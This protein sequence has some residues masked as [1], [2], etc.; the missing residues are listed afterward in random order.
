MSHQDDCRKYE[1]TKKGFLMRLYRN[2]KSRTLGIQKQKAH[3]YKGLELLSKEKFYLWAESNEE[4]HRLFRIWK[5][6]NFHRLLT[7]TVDRKD[8]QLG[9]KISNMRWITH[10]EN[11]SLGAFSKHR[12]IED[13]KR[14]HMHIPDPK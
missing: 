14:Q 7:P 10:S 12:Q 4:F 13:R 11:S 6:F 5:D 2:M 3:L 9:Y 1:K 8:A